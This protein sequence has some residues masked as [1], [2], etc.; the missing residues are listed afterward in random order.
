MHKG[1]RNMAPPIKLPDLVVAG[2]TE[3]PVLDFTRPPYSEI[4][5]LTI[6][7]PAVLTE[8]ATIH[9]SAK[10]G[11]NIGPLQSGGA[12]VV[13]TQDDALVISPVTFAE[14]K[15]VL[16]VIGTR[17]FEMGGREVT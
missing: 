6:I 5:D 7:G 17:T 8:V 13:V 1:E 16:S 2:G 9:V 3:S 4:K 12:D 11:G 10:K 15:I 14:F